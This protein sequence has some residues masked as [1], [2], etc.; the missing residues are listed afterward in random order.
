MHNDIN[1][2]IVN[3]LF[4]L[5]SIPTC[6]CK[7][8]YFLHFALVSYFVNHSHSVLMQ[9]SAKIDT[10]L[11]IL[12]FVELEFLWLKYCVYQILLHLREQIFNNWA[13]HYLSYL[14]KKLIL[15]LEFLGTT[16]YLVI[17]F[18]FS[19]KNLV[20]IKLW[21]NSVEKRGTREF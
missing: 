4:H 1:L 2:H 10:L 18:I 17:F 7:L 12:F 14:T 11:W 20:S 13:A 8:L 9:M 3:N 6:V 19:C 21:E 5:N 16:L 15:K